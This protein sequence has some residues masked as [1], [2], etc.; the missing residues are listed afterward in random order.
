MALLAVPAASTNGS[1]GRQQVA[2]ARTLPTADIAAASPPLE[3]DFPTVVIV[4]VFMDV[5]TFKYIIGDR[6]PAWTSPPPLGAHEFSCSKVRSLG[7]SKPTTTSPSIVVTGVVMYPIFS[8][9]LSA[10]S[11]VAIFRS[12]KFI[13]F[14]ER[15]S[16]TLLQ[17]S[18]PGWL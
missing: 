14:W 12:I 18:Q 17:N 3:G 7:T 8:S 13:L 11:S 5:F 2:A 9:S 1:T 16:F 10:V 15:N 6:S 4:S